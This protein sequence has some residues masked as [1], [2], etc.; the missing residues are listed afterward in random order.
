M[1]SIELTPLAADKKTSLTINGSE[2]LKEEIQLNF[3]ETK[4]DIEVTSPDKTSTKV[5][6][7]TV[8][9]E[10]LLRHVVFVDQQAKANNECPICL[11][12]LYRPKSIAGSKTG[13][14]FCKSCI[15]ELTRTSK[16]DPLDDTPLV[17]EWRVDEFDLEKTQS[18]ADV[19][20]VFAHW[21]CSDKTKLCDLG[22]HAIQC[23]CR[24]VMIEK[25][26]EM[27]PAKDVE[28]K[29]KVDNILIRL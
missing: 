10:Q 20:C 11:G 7:V 22:G 21:G 25:S 29:A 1:S 17:G 12:V 5:Y 14:V 18:S 24:P 23:A 13:H 8:C 28:T 9:K 26:L 16:Q 19:H 2:N 27:V 3:G 15:D 6:T 4:V